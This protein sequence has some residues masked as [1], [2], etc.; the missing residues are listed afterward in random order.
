MCA[1]PANLLPSPPTVQVKA[2]AA[3][4]ELILAKDP[5]MDQAKALREFSEAGPD[6][7]TEAGRTRTRVIAVT[8]GKGGVGKTSITANLACILSRRDQKTLVID[9]DTGLA[10]IDVVLGLTPRYNLYHV[11]AGEKKLSEAMVQAPGGFYVLPASS[12]IQEMAELTKGQKIS[13]IEE[14]N[15]WPDKLNFLLLDTAAGISANVLYFNMTAKEIIL[16]A[17]PDPTSLTDAYAL[18]K[19]LFQRH[20]KKRFMLIV[21]MVKNESEAREVFERL[22]Q[23]TDHFLNLTIDYLGFVLDDS[24]LKKSIRRQRALAELFPQAPASRCLENIADRLLKMVVSHEEGTLT[25]FDR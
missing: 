2:F 13:L 14:I 12:G 7:S 17:T 24:N 6:E 9:A 19:V 11:L 4:Y 8:S 18:I 10:N 16:V 3:F 20:A 21:N 25:F 22:N 1:L 23:A 15:S 5:Q